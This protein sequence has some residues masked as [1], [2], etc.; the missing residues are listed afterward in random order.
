[1]KIQSIRG[2]NDIALEESYLW[3][4]IE[5]HARQVFESY[6][7][8][9]IRTPLLESTSLFK[10]GVGET[11]DIV[12]KEMY[13]F[14]DRGGDSLSLRPE[15]TA[16]TVRAVVQHNWV[17]ENPV[18][19][20]YYIGPMF[21]RERPQKGRYRQFFQLGVELFGV[22][23]PMADVEVIH[24]Q[25]QLF[26]RLG[27]EQFELQIS[28]IGCDDCRP[29]YKD[30]LIEI[31]T[32]LKQELCDNCQRRMDTN[33]L[34]VL[35]CKEK[36]CQAIAAELPSILDHLCGVC[37]PHFDKVRDGLVALGVPFKVNPKIVRGLDYYNRTAF[38]FVSLDDS[39]GTQATISGGGRYDKLVE[40]L[41]GNATPAVGFA[42]G[43]ERL[44]LILEPMKEKL[45]PRVD[46][47]LIAPDQQ[48]LEKCL[49]LTGALRSRGIRAEMDLQGKSFK[50]Q[51]KRANK[52]KSRYAL[53]VGESEIQ[54]NLAILKNMDE[55]TQEEILLT[56]ID[57]KLKELFPKTSN[58]RF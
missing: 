48:G 23:G 35:D 36:K 20:Q 22:E 54:N 19:K 39:L 38:E 32:P 9:E 11:T 12:E 16:S 27:V 50:A 29:A 17:R 13:S 2:M 41:G 24:I 45:Q 26:K 10:R 28:S 31:L 47:F 33:P 55:G 40:Q 5:S 15:G 46:V 43:I 4:Y 6:G 52:L 1:M 56:K 37:E 49:P 42:A 51:L 25:H 58:Y 7:F 8:S 34:R 14:E 30:M 53:I 44:A 3:R 18:L 21:R 57:E